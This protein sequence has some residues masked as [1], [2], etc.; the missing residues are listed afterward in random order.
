[1]RSSRSSKLASSRS[2]ERS[3]LPTRRTVP[4]AVDAGRRMREAVRSLR[5]RTVGRTSKRMTPGRSWRVHPHDGANP[6]LGQCR[7]YT[8]C[9]PLGPVAKAVGGGLS[10]AARGREGESGRGRLGRGLA[11]GTPLVGPLGP[12]R[13]VAGQDAP[14][15]RDHRRGRRASSGRSPDDFGLPRDPRALGAPREGPAAGCSCVQLSLHPISIKGVSLTRVG[16]EDP[17]VARNHS[18]GH[19]P[20][21]SSTPTADRTKRRAQPRWFRSRKTVWAAEVTLGRLRV[22]SRTEDSPPPGGGWPDKERA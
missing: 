12:G 20:L 13:V 11:R 4:L 14:G 19:R 1:M 6:A 10:R 3:G 21:R 18:L 22:T 2:L 17:P 16:S 15:R 5:A 8:E 7:Q 9:H